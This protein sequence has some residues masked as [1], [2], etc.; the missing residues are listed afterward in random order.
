[1][2]QS[3]ILRAPKLTDKLAF[4]RFYQNYVENDPENVSFHTQ[5]FEDFDKHIQLIQFLSRGEH[6]PKHAVPTTQ[7]WAFNQAGE[8]VGTLSIRHNISNLYLENEAG[9]IGY[10][11]AP[12]FRGRGYAKI[13]LKLAQTEMKKIGL[14]K[15][16]ITC[17][18]NNIAS[19]KV[20]LDSG[21]IYSHT[22]MGR[23]CP[24]PISHY[25]LNL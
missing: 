14:E 2:R 20:I 10:D 15:V 18:D 12:K 1:M 16:L 8:M 4:M 17:Q 6:L 7:L 9:H 3:L 25:W 5:G 21:G 22:I 24:Y 19:K 13:M 23:V 11:V